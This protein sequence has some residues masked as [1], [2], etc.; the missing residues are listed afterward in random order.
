M[1]NRFVQLLAIL[2]L[3]TVLISPVFAQ[4]PLRES[5]EEKGYSRVNLLTGL[6]TEFN[7]GLAI[8]ISHGW[9]SPAPWKDLAGPQKAEF[10]KTAS[11]TLTIDDEPVKLRRYQWIST[12]DNQWKGYMYIVFW[13]TFPSN[14][15]AVDDHTFDG[16]W[17]VYVNG[18]EDYLEMSLTISVTA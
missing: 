18:V 12:E 8:S 17:S 2:I 13:I 6:P 3:F 14:T 5:L 11:F 4:T 9:T 15:F 7:T 16:V 1:K 10:V